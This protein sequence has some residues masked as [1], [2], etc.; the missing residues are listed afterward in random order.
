MIARFD[1]PCGHFDNNG[2]LLE[3]SMNGGIVSRVLALQDVVAGVM[4]QSVKMKKDRYYSIP[5]EAALELQ[6]AGYVRITND[7][8][9]QQEIGEREQPDI[10]A[11]EM[12]VNPKAATRKTRKL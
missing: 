5:V 8:D 4:G 9:S 7:D 11:R 3:I 12:A 6:R 1:V 10:T 2:A